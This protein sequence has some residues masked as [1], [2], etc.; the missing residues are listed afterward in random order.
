MNLVH[1]KEKSIFGLSARTNNAA[2]MNPSTGKIG[3]LVHKFDS[4][5]EVDYRGGARVYSVYYSYESDVTGDYSVLVGA[6][7]VASS[8]VELSEVKIQEGD[9]LVF[10][11]SGQVPQIVIETWQ[12]I[13]SYFA[14]PGC[15]HTRA[16]ETDFEFYKSQNDIEIYIGVKQ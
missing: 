2:E 7:V 8:S 9:Y 11:G 12:K 15:P 4:Q 5:V 16:Y 10:S 6:D 3:P 13:W 14:N 1:L